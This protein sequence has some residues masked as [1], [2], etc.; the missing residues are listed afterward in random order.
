MA[1]VSDARAESIHDLG[2]LTLRS[3]REGDMHVVAFG[4]ELDLSGLGL[5]E[6]ELGRVEASDAGVI[7]L[8]LAELDFID[9]GGVRLVVLADRRE[10]D[11]LVVVRGRRG[12]QRV[13]ELCG[14]VRELLF[15]DACPQATRA[16]ET[17]TVVA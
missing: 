3:F 1:D 8:D 9:S 11:R 4:G 13:F 6:R 14:V 10:H 7:V 5:V 12:V 15:V 16:T 2:A 17:R